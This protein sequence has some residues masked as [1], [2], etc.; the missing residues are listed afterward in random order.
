MWVLMGPEDVKVTR[1]VSDGAVQSA[2]AERLRR[3]V[4]EAI[5]ILNTSGMDR[6]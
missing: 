2:L 3:C 1:Q 6:R 4:R 5:E